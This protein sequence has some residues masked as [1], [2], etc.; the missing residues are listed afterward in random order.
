MHKKMYIHIYNEILAYK[1]V[2]KRV[3][4]IELS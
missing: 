3:D 4:R 2:F 1:L